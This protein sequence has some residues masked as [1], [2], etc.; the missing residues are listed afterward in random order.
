VQALEKSRPRDRLG[1]TDPGEPNI[2]E[3]SNLGDSGTRSRS[4]GLFRPAPCGICRE[5]P[6]T[7]KLGRRGVTGLEV[8]EMS[9]LVVW[10][11]SRKA[12][13]GDNEGFGASDRERDFDEDLEV[14]FPTS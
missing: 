1:N 11:D 8:M 5:R 6:R 14:S 10:E 4:F 3:A 7:G 2:C 12:G 9:S 13:E